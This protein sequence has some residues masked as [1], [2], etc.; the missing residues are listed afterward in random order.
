VLLNTLTPDNEKYEKLV[1]GLEKI[2][3]IDNTLDKI[4]SKKIE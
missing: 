1:A 2:R 3:Q 4:G